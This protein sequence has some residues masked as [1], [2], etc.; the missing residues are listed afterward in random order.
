MRSRRADAETHRY[1]VEEG[2]EKPPPPPES[3]VD[4]DETAE[5]EEVAE[6]DGVELL[7]DMVVAEHEMERG[8]DKATRSSA[9]TGT[10][11]VTLVVALCRQLSRCPLAAFWTPQYTP[12][13]TLIT[14]ATHSINALRLSPTVTII[15]KAITRL[16]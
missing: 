2:G 10:S 8:E 11:L 16:L 14:S 15:Q 3:D 5:S 4:E 13:D 9:S 7:L 12:L 6:G 1:S